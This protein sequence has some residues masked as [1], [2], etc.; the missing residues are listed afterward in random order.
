V[1]CTASHKAA[2]LRH[3]RELPKLG[4]AGSLPVSFKDLSKLEKL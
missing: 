1:R 4:L 3:C 2:P